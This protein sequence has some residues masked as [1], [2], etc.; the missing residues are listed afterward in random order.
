[1]EK[2]FMQDFKAAQRKALLNYTEP[3]K[4][5]TAARNFAAFI[6]RHRDAAV[7]SVGIACLGVT[8]LPFK[9]EEAPAKPAA[10]QEQAAE[11]PS[12]HP[13]GSE[14]LAKLQMKKSKSLGM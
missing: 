8:S 1:M 13:G 2:T 14:S 5:T 11:T 10:K 7:L 9:T 6:H 3:S 12:A 4:L